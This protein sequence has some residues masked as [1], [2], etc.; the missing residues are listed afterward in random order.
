MPCRS[1]AILMGLSTLALAM[2]PTPLRAQTPDAPSRRASFMAG[3]SLGD[4]ETAPALSAGL[5]WQLS[6]RV[7][8]EFELAYARK[9]D[10]TLDL[11]P[12]PLVCVRGGRL[13][14]T[15]RTVSLV[16]HVVIDLR[17]DAR[18]RPYVL[19]GVGV[20]HVRQRYF[21]PPLGSGGSAGGTPLEYTRSNATV[22]FS[23]GGGIDVSIARRLA[24]GADVRALIIVDETASPDRFITPSGALHTVRVGSRVSYRF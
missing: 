24:I 19:A 9:L 13:P 4:G 18:I 20:G 7:G 8:I 6:P 1:A 3:A 15:G 17:P 10:F 21:D 2:V 16:P 14:V 12:A 5:G 22:A 11:C 23:A